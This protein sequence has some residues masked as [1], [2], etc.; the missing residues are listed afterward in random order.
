MTALSV[1]LP[2]SN[3]AE[4]IGDCLESLFASLPIAGGAE[5]IVVANGCKDATVARAL[6]YESRARAAGW[7]MVVL[8]L[9]QGG[10]LNAL[11]QGEAHVQG[12][13]RAYLDADVR[14]EPP[15]LAALVAQLSQKKALY[16]SGRPKVTAPKS[17]VTKAYARFWQGLP[18]AGS[19]APGFGLFAVNA[20]GRARWGEFPDIIS[21]DTFV[22]LHFTPDERREVPFTYSW[23]MV[24]GFA[25][26]VKVRRRQDAGVQ[27]LARKYPELLANE[28]K[29]PL[30]KKRLLGMAAGDPKGVFVYAM[31]SL[32]VRLRG[33][34]GGWTRGR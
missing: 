1:I 31:V 11:N 14:L 5:V 30:G 9:A 7:R 22:R 24:E 28:G 26:L 10:K 32:A 2:A 3:E 18:F 27:E 34:D 4:W 23:P 20:Q 21:D 12:H 33:A 25:A 29:T 19:V 6:S 15:L 8:D 17:W 13:I 16:G